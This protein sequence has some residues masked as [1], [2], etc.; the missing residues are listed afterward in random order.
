MNL[1]QAS[2]L[3][4]EN[5]RYFSELYKSFQFRD[6]QTLKEYLDFVI[7]EPLEWLKSF[8][9]KLLTKSTFSRPKAV[10]I[11]LLKMDEVKTV[12]GGDYAKNVYDTI[13]KTFKDHHEEILRV[14]NSVPIGNVVDQMVEANESIH[15]DSVSENIVAEEI[16]PQAELRP[17]GRVPAHVCERCLALEKNLNLSLQIN[18][19]LLQ[20]YR[21][22][23]PGLMESTT[24][25]VDSLA[26]PSLPSLS[27]LSSPS[28]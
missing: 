3:L 28:S 21:F 5:S 27:S 18:R 16:E 7:H 1:T 8:P 23:V 20:E 22:V 26:V 14:R 11:K 9:S 2:T 25:L 10:I 17:R 4:G 12:I 24:L 19:T 13:W 15:D 6:E